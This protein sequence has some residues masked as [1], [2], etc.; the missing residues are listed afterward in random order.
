MIVKIEQEKIT[1]AS[2]SDISP[3]TYPEYF[4][5]APAPQSA[6]GS[7]CPTLQTEIPYPRGKTWK[8]NSTLASDYFCFSWLFLKL[9]RIGQYS[10][11]VKYILN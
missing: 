3:L 1:Q 8:G 11:G 10:R 6:V 7:A 2:A 4:A 9:A 5:W